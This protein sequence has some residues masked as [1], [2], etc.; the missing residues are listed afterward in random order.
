MTNPGMAAP[1]KTRRQ[2]AIF[3]DRDDTL[4]V[5]RHGYTYLVSDFKFVA[6]AAAAL[7][8]FHNAGLRAFV[9]T[10]QGGIGKGLFQR[11]DMQRFNDKLLGETAAN[12]GQITDIAYCPHHPD[13]VDPDLRAPCA[14]RKPEPG[15]LLTLAAK[16]HIDLP[17]SVMVGDRDSDVAAGRAAG[18]HAYR[19][20]G[21]S[22]LSLSRHILATHFD[23]AG[24]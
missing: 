12:G 24:L 6:G 18:C 11:E 5:D 3:F 17:R 19:F 2:P 14:C 15:M 22:L 16:W 8:L 1:N 4:T 13:A 10:N 23:G 20:D 9:V 21:G 7:A